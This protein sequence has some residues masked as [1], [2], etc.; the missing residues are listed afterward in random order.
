MAPSFP[1]LVVAPERLDDAILS[2]GL[3]RRLAEEVPH[4][5]FVVAAGAQTAPLYRD[6][7]TLDQL[8]AFEP[9]PMGLEWLDLWTRAR[10]RRWGLVLDLRGG[11][12]FA[13]MLQ[14]RRRAVR[15]PCNPALDPIHKVLEAARVL[16]LDDEPPAPHLYVSTE[17]EAEAAALLEPRR[18]A[19]DG[20]ILALAPNAAWVGRAWAA[21]RFAVVA[22]EFLGPNGP[23]PDGRLM[24]LGAAEDRWATE[25]VRRATA[26]ERLIDLAGKDLLVAYAA[27]K[28]AR[29]FI[30]VDNPYLHLAAAAGAPT[31][32]LF[33]PSDERAYGPW[34]PKTRVVR[35]PR[36]YETFKALDPAF[37]QA[38]N[39]MQDLT[40]AK[41]TA[42]ARRLMAET[43]PD[44]E[45]ADEGGVT[46]A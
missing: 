1:I 16:K 32:A 8:W 21:E 41:V 28:R 40:V 18:G 14:A 3:I 17:A 26:R 13:R 42:A 29:L 31:L 25:T 38:M 7:P 35:G 10:G 37:S 2:S 15:R 9:K 36:D 11:G 44:V 43:E 19:P 6:I 4:A 22:A 27:L 24:L 20:P 12:R 46:R 5:R 33:G 30:G 34:G 39:H 45:P 23:M